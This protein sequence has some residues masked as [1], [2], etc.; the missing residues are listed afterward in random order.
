MFEQ[1]NST[2][3]SSDLVDAIVVDDS[4]IEIDFS[5]ITFVG[6]DGQ[7]SFYDGS[8]SELGIGSGTL[9]T[10]GDGNPPTEN[11]SGSFGL[12][13]NGITSDPQ[14][15][16]VADSAFTD[17]GEVQDINSLEF[18]FTITDPNVE[19]V[20]FNL[21]FGSDEFPEFSDSS[22]VDVGAVFI[23]DQNVGL[24]NNDPNQPLSI[25]SENLELGNYQDNAN[26]IIPIEYDGV[27]SC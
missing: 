13:Q 5:S 1:Y 15:Q 3:N 18:N 14:L 7:A 25:I 12:S 27:S 9:L 10:S 20:S 19:S 21:V 11:T 2:S 6:A 17:S 22:F 23:N 16:A 4:G 26:N 24:F 8:I